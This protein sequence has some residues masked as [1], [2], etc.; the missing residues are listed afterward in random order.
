[1]PPVDVMDAELGLVD[2]AEEREQVLVARPDRLVALP[3][4]PAKRLLLELRVDA[5]RSVPREAGAD[6]GRVE[7]EHG[8]EVAALDGLRQVP[9]QLGVQRVDDGPSRRL[10]AV[11]TRR[12]PVQDQGDADEQAP[13]GM[14]SSA[15]RTAAL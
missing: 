2:L 4:A 1:M 14:G 8:S 10:P 5:R 13:A 7:R 9:M 15:H 12:R 6:L 3:S 11:R